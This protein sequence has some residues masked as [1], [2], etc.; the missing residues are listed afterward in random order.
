WSL[1]RLKVQMACPPQGTS[2]KWPYNH[3]MLGTPKMGCETVIFASFSAM[4]RA[5]CENLR[6]TLKHW[7]VKAVR[8]VQ[9]GV[10]CVVTHNTLSLAQAP[11][12]LALSWQHWQP[13]VM[14]H[15]KACWMSYFLNNR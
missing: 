6:L 4:S 8:T 3:W 1:L 7:H 14:Q 5:Q 12:W 11:T 2:P 10:C 15:L 13:I 9:S